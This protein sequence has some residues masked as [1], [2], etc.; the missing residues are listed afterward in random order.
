MD[1]N[2]Q[3][4]EVRRT[5]GSRAQERATQKVREMA[6]DS[7]QDHRLY[8]IF[9]GPGYKMIK[10]VFLVAGELRLWEGMNPKKMSLSTRQI[11][12]GMIELSLTYPEPP[13]EPTASQVL[14]DI[15]AALL[16]IE[17]IPEDGGYSTVRTQ[18][19]PVEHWPKPVVAMA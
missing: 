12:E 13:P 6:M 14:R 16:P 2:L 5:K 7:C 18:V 11:S 3:L 17:I 8:R 10:V 1:E 19:L 9:D 15:V 4:I